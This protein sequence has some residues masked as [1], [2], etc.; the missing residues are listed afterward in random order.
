M[1]L[2]IISIIYPIFGLGLILIG[3]IK[4]W[5][6]EVDKK[7]KKY[8]FPLALNFGVYGYSFSFYENTLNDLTKYFE[9]VLEISSI[10]FNKLISLDTDF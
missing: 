8:I 1:E 2:L 7:L 4:N 5:N 3:L 9:Q 6:N 10:S